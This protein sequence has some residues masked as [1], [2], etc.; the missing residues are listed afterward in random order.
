MAPTTTPLR[1]YGGS[2]VVRSAALQ[3]YEECSRPQ[4]ERMLQRWRP[5]TLSQLITAH[6]VPG[7]TPVNTVMILQLLFHLKSSLHQVSSLMYKRMQMYCMY[8]FFAY[9]IVSIKLPPVQFWRI[10][11]T[12]Y[13]GPH[14]SAPQKYPVPSLFAVVFT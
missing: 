14:L 6:S 10:T 9:K 11:Y 2:M 8:L 1:S 4:P 5:C 3:H 12:M 7:C 13:S